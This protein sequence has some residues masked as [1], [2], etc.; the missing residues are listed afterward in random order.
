MGGVKPEDIEAIF[1]KQ[2]KSGSATYDPN[3]NF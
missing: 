1:K 3:A 2:N